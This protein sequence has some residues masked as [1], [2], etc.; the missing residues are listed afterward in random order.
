MQHK[1]RNTQIVRYQNLSNHSLSHYQNE[2]L[3]PFV[4]KIQTI[5]LS[6]PVQD[7]L[8]LYQEIVIAEVYFEKVGV[9]VLQLILL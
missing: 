6:F 2:H 5:W 8:R 3:Y 4:F 7:T 9:A 1:C